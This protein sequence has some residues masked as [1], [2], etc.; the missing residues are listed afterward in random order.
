MSEKDLRV[1]YLRGLLLDE[2]QGDTDSIHVLG[3]ILEDPEATVDDD[4]VEVLRTDSMQSLAGVLSNLALS[5]D[6]LPIY[7]SP[8]VITTYSSIYD[9]YRSA[10]DKKGPLPTNFLDMLY[11]IEGSN[12]EVDSFLEKWQGPAPIFAS[13]GR[14]S[15]EVFPAKGKFNTAVIGEFDDRL[16]SIEVYP[17]ICAVFSLGKRISLKSRDELIIIEQEDIAEKVIPLHGQ[18][19]KQHVRYDDKP[20]GDYRFF[21]P[22]DNGSSLSSEQRFLVRAAISSIVD[23][24]PEGTFDE[25]ELPVIDLPDREFRNK[26]LFSMSASLIQACGPDNL[27]IDGPHNRGQ[28]SV[29]KDVIKRQQTTLSGLDFNMLDIYLD[30]A[31]LSRKV[32]ALTAMQELSIR[33]PQVRDVINE[34]DRL[35]TVDV[36]QK[37]SKRWLS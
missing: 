2:E 27:F 28:L 14:N 20:S 19:Q 15:A 12:D 35:K 30:A 11:K 17:A 21:E 10:R 34:I 18:F 8:Q 23:D 3:R 9:I 25:V 36:L 16:G 29:D 5:G 37:V 33:Q 31:G 13:L 1:D 6:E 24:S 7:S 4:Q 32:I 22:S 26:L